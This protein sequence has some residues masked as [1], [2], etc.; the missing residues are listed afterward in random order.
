MVF[1]CL[2][3]SCAISCPPGPFVSSCTVCRSPRRGGLCNPIPRFF[4]REEETLHVQRQRMVFVSQIF[5]RNQTQVVF[6]RSRFAAVKFEVFLH[7]ADEKI[8]SGCGHEVMWQELTC[9]ILYKRENATTGVLTGME[10]D[11]QLAE[12]C[13]LQL[14]RRAWVFHL[15]EWS[16]NKFGR[17]IFGRYWGV[18]WSHEHRC[19]F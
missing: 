18:P 12:C 4:L 16:E 3:Y 2:A 19:S 17:A 5:A 1:E 11:K 7:A 9:Q 14:F 8:C 10:R 6:H 15:N 13:V